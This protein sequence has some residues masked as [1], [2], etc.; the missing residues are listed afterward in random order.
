MGRYTDQNEL[1]T[2]GKQM[3]LHC[4]IE[5]TVFGQ[6]GSPETLVVV[7]SD[8]DDLG[9]AKGGKTDWRGVILSDSGRVG[10]P[11]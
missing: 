1:A 10:G 4:S 7:V 6:L 5:H 11:P 9:Q 2:R 3:E 8:S